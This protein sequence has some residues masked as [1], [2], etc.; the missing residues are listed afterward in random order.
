MG[1]K[2]SKQ[3]SQCPILSS[4]MYELFSFR[5]TVLKEARTEHMQTQK[6]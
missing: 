6:A 2:K 3:K 1:G 4:F 5:A